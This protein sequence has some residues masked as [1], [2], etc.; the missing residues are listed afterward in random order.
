MCQRAFILGERY[1][2]SH[3]GSPSCSSLNEAV[4]DALESALHDAP[5]LKS[6]DIVSIKPVSL[7]KR[8]VCFTE[9]AL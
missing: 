3:K 7:K 1:D 6:F 8:D 9:P 2:A 5:Y 4:S